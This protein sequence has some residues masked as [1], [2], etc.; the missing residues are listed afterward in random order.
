MPVEQAAEASR[1]LEYANGDL[2]T[3]IAIAK[4]PDVPPRSACFHAQQCAEK[5]LKA[6]L[7]HVGIEPP[8]L[9]NL[10][11][12][13]ELLPPS[14]RVR[15]ATDLGRLTF[16]AAE[17]RYPSD[18]GEASAEDV[19]IAIDTSKWIYD[20][21]KRDIAARTSSGSTDEAESSTK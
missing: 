18:S 13:V 2:R 1:W 3:A 15:T 17:A 20:A 16:W 12:L 10:A 14:W 6:A 9:H 11:S 8:K 4:D 7:I 21:V 19:R 5:S